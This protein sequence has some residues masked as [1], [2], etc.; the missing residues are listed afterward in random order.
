MRHHPFETS[1]F[2]VE[3]IQ[4]HFTEE[5]KSQAASIL[6]SVDFLGNPLGF[7]NDVAE[8]VSGLLEGNVGGLFKNVTHGV[9]N[10]AAKVQYDALHGDIDF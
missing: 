3:S 5:L 9:S 2:L 4:H 6:G 1:A 8:G 10:S 7:F